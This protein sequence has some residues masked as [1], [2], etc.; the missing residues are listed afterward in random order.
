MPPGPLFT[1]AGSIENEQLNIKGTHSHYHSRPHLHSLHSL[2]CDCQVL[3]VIGTSAQGPPLRQA[4]P[5]IDEK[6]TRKTGTA[7]RT[8]GHSASPTQKGLVHISTTMSDTLATSSIPSPQ[9]TL[10]DGRHPTVDAVTRRGNGSSIA[11]D[12]RMNAGIASGGTLE[13]QQSSG[14]RTKQE[15]RADEDKQEKGKS[16]YRYKGIAPDAP[17]ESFN[18]RIRGFTF[19]WFTICMATAGLSIILGECARVDEPAGSSG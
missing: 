17:R 4:T 11:E 10:L 3:Q 9:H 13:R 5:V 12:P 2:A 18:V 14:F 7:A 19:A 16:D 6:L 1:F 15:R 8:S